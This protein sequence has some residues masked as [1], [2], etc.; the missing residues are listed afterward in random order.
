MAHER[1]STIDLCV[2]LRRASGRT[3]SALW[4]LSRH[5]D[6]L[7]VIGPDLNIGKAVVAKQKLVAVQ[8]IL[9]HAQLG[10]RISNV[11]SPKNNTTYCIS[12]TL[13]R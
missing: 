7:L 8:A 3:S 13:L 4:R 9:S 1:R 10:Q 5:Y 12:W 11:D 6:L 2:G